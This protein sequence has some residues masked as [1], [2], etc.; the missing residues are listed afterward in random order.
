VEDVVEDVEEE[1][2]TSEAGEDVAEAEVEEVDA[3]VEE[4]EVA[5]EDFLQPK[6]KVPKHLRVIK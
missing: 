1:E 5:E 3:V 6:L 4:A 2:V